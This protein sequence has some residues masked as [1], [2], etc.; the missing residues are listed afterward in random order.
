MSIVMNLYYTGQ[1][2]NARKFAK[3][4]EDRGASG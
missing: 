4:M 1:N 3:E 2:G